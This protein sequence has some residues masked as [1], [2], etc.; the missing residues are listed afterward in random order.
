MKKL[1]IFLALFFF[2]TT[3]IL[4]E[5]NFSRLCLEVSD[6]PLLGRGRNCIFVVSGEVKYQISVFDPKVKMKPAKYPYGL[7]RGYLPAAGW[8]GFEKFFIFKGKVAAITDDSRVVVELT[9]GNADFAL[10]EMREFLE[11]VQQINEG[12]LNKNAEQIEKAAKKSGGLVIDHAPKGMLA[13]LPIGFKELGFATH[14][15]FDEIADSIQVNKNVKQTHSQLG[16]LLNN[17]VACHKLYKI[18]VVLD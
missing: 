11:S 13:S 7:P 16:K 6:S 17:C 10:D 12:I 1:P 4:I 15:L 5:K 18:Q 14:D 2:L 8:V 3:V 9:E